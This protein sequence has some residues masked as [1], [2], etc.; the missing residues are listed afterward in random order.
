MTLHRLTIPVLAILVLA[1]SSVRA[2]ESYLEFVNELRNHDY[3]DYALLYLENLEK[4]S[5]IPS[6]IKEVIPYEKGITLVEGAKRETSPEGQTKQLD[7]ARGFLDQF[8]KASPNHPNAGKANT[9]LANVI[10]GK[11]KVEVLQAKSPSNSGQKGEHQKKARAYFD[12]AKKVFQAAHDRY[13]EAYDKFDKFIPKDQKDKYAAREE[14]YRHFIQ[15]QLNL[16]VLNYE[17]AQTYDKGS[18]E[19][20]KRLSDA[21]KEFSTIHARYRQQVAGLYAR[22]WEGKC[23]EEDDDIV[24][25][26]GI[27]NELLGHEPGKGGTTLKN[28]QDR[29]RHFRLI[30]LNRDQRKDY[31]VV[32]QEAQEWLKENRGPAGN[33]RTGLGIQWEMVRAQELLAKK[34]DTPEADK[35]RMLHQA[36]TTARTINKYPGEYK[37]VS[38]AMIS[39]LMVLLDREPGDPKDFATAFGVGRNLIQDISKRS[40][41][42]GKATG[43]EQAKMLADLQ[44][45]L[46]EAARILNIALT[47]ATPKDDPKE[48]NQA[49]YFLAYVY[50]S[51][52]DGGLDRSYDA[53]VL[54]EY[55]AK[56]AVTTRPDFAIDAAYLAQA[57]YIQAYHREVEDN[58]PGDFKR[59]ISICNFITGNWP[60]NDKANDARM[61]LGR[62][63]NEIGQPAEAAKWLMQVP[64]AAPQYLDAQLAA[65][66]AFWYAYLTESIRPEAERKS[67][68]ELDALLKQSQDILRTVITKFESQLPAEISQ[69]D[70]GKLASLTQAKVNYS[71]I[72]NS[73][74]DFKGALAI[75][76]DGHLAVVTAVAAPEGDEKKRLPRGIKSKQYAGIVYQVVLRTY[77]GLQDLDKAR[78]TMRELE[79]IVGTGGGGASLTKIYL[80]LGKE[81]QK[82]VE[83]LQAAQDPRLAEVLK[84]FE[85]F[86]EDMSGRKEGQDFNSLIWVAE[87]YRALGEGLQQGDSAKAESYFGKAVMALQQLLDKPDLIPSGGLLGVKLKIVMC[88]RREKDFEEAHKQLIAVLQEKA[89][90]LDVQEEAARLFEDWA[91]RGASGDIDKWA[92]AIEGG[93]VNKKNKEDRKVWGWFGLADKLRSTLQNHANPEYEQKYLDAS[94]NVANCW[95]KSARAQETNATRKKQLSEAY[96]AVERP[97]ILIPTLGGGESWK[98]FNK[99]YREIQQEMLDL[100]MEQMRGKEIVDFRL[101][102]EERAQLAAAQ[103]KDGDEAQADELPPDTG[104]KPKKRKTEKA[105][106]KP[107]AAAGTNWTPLIVG[108][109]V[110]CG[111]GGGAYYYLNQSRGKKKKRRPV[112]AAVDD[113]PNFGALEAP[114]APQ[115][116]KRQNVK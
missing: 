76:G 39:R 30:C 3:Y 103:K 116:K 36:L 101:T 81:L 74:G 19:N 61:A 34:E 83:R 31:Q 96:K 42:I 66:N 60:T 2:A 108:L 89:N 54:A 7:L 38:T 92:I 15:A 77:V 97:A 12:E 28:L 115:P 88:K 105:G 37:D 95:F 55:I 25:A 56:K 75:L 11:G 87:T 41:T 44:P 52:R 51:M 23:F 35:N 99:L 68:E 69:V 49:R 65:G 91:A 107:K 80:D 109:V 40:D 27:Y 98:K 29:V 106:A 33:T 71:Q 4:R 100:K 53:A 50:Y 111:G 18:A 13:K 79:K 63:Y 67:K 62:V 17:E 24:K 57:A 110:L 64:E 46:K 48:V 82:E 58:R 94:Y 59:V 72:L 20:K 21:A 9:E 102:K 22:L 47:V 104:T 43:S 6:D 112:V 85:T 1:A 114:A 113:E 14:A 5:D 45:M 78:E 84:S 16:A 86:L 90:A 70:E 26:L 93:R 73:S 32:I 8:L 10:V